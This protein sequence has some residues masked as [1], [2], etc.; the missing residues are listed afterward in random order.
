MTIALSTAAGLACAFYLFVL[1]KFA[2]ASYHEILKAPLALRYA[3]LL[4]PP[5]QGKAHDC[6]VLVC[7]SQASA[8]LKHTI[9]QMDS[10]TRNLR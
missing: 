5:F 3:N 8:L 10:S 9:T 2:R 4:A 6:G 1:V 7:D